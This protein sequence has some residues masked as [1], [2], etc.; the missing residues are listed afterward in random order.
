ME[1]ATPP[2][3]CRPYNRVCVVHGKRGLS[4][5]LLLSL[6]HVVHGYDMLNKGGGGGGGV[7]LARSLRIRAHPRIIDCL[8]LWI[9]SMLRRSCTF[10]VKMT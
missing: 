6:D 3:L 5:S 2:L 4:G 7:V 8:Y 1:L 9:G 10:H